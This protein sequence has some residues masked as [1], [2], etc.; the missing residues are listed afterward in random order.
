MEKKLDKIEQKL[1]KIS[2]ELAEI[3]ITLVEQNKDLKY[4]IHRTNL[5]EDHVK[6]LEN[7]L[8]PI[9]KHISMVEGGLKLVGI[10][11]TLTTLAMGIVKLLNFL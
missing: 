1:D 9:D 7:K 10:L 4:H 5:L 11:A 2:E 6:I 8:N 3:N